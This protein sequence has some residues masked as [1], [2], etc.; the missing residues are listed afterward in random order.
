VAAAS[1]ARASSK[2]AP[3]ANPSPRPPPPQLHEA[4][5]QEESIGDGAS[6]L[7]LVMSS[8]GHAQRTM[9]RA[10]LAIGAFPALYRRWGFA[11]RV[12]RVEGMGTAPGT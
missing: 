1:F 5:A 10:R 7:R 6:T 2:S 4:R 3:L 12:A 9:M 11:G 8:R